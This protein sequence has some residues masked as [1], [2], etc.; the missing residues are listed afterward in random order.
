MACLFLLVGWLVVAA[1]SSVLLGMG[2]Y[3]CSEGF[4]AH[5]RFCCS[6]VF[7]FYFNFCAFSILRFP[8]GSLE[9][10]KDDT[11]RG[12]ITLGEETRPWFPVPT[13]TSS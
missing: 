6:S 5:H 13:S 8:F 7:P 4:S 11:L 10:Q 1:V 3:F 9:R 12:C 2:D